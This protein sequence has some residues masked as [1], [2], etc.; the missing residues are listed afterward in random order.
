MA[1]ANRLNKGFSNQRLT[2]ISPTTATSATPTV[3]HRDTAWSAGA[4]D[5]NATMASSGTMA[6]SSSNKMDTMRWPRGV[7]VSPLSSNSCITMAV[8]D[9]T[10]P[11]AA[12]KATAADSPASTPV[13]MSS[14]IHTTT[15]ASP[16]PKI[17]RR[18]FHNRDGCISS[19][20]TKRNITTPN[21][22]TCRMVCASLKKPMP[23]GP[24]ASPAAR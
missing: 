19:P 24:M 7:D 23:K 4:G 17:C 21:S 3:T 9:S 12:M 6:R 13:A 1:R 14:A 22:A 5:R 15:W 8:D 11:E 18:R 16:S 20:M 2:A 10:N